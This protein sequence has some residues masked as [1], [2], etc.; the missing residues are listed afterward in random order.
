MNL[1]KLLFGRVENVNEFIDKSN[2]KILKYA[3]WINVAILFVVFNFLGGNAGL[4]IWASTGDFRE[5]FQLFGEIIQGPGV[6][7]LV[8]TILTII[9]T[10]TLLFICVLRGKHTKELNEKFWEY[11][12]TIESDENLMA[13]YD[14][15]YRKRAKNYVLVNGFF[16]AKDKDSRVKN[17]YKSNTVACLWLTIFICIGALV[18]LFSFAFWRVFSMQWAQELFMM[19]GSSW[20]FLLCVVLPIIYVW[21]T[22]KRFATHKYYV[23]NV[24]AQALFDESYG[25]NFDEGFMNYIN[26]DKKLSN[27]AVKYQERHTKGRLF[28]LCATWE[29]RLIFGGFIAVMFIYVWIVVWLLAV[30]TKGFL[31]DSLS[32]SSSSSYSSSSSSSYTSSS[33][34]SSSSYDSDYQTAA[35]PAKR[36]VLVGRG[37]NEYY[38]IDGRDIREG[39][40]TPYGRIVNGYE[41]HGNEIW[42]QKDGQWKTMARISTDGSDGSVMY[43]YDYEGE[44]IFERYEWKA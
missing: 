30:I 26:A 40:G 2:S 33:S 29:D 18:L 1:K 44:K 38:E 11:K 14:A 35:A 13:Q 28:A 43:S 42:Y 37:W 25:V 24:T 9:F 3:F 23:A 8:G 32:S 4:R 39:L 6:I 7:N 15:C 12:S 17:G 19:R 16:H 20:L 41:V 34:S 22:K 21:Y 31:G 36:L 27:L 5:F 10:A